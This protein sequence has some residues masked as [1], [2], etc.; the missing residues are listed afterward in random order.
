MNEMATPVKED[1]Y[2]IMA[3]D[4]AVKILNSFN[5]NEQNDVIKLVIERVYVHRQEEIKDLKDKIEYL[6]GALSNLRT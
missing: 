6:A 4:F 1:E 3:N 2:M 5:A